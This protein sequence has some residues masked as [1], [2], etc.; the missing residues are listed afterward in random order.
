MTNHPSYRPIALIT[1]AS[2]GIGAAAGRVFTAGGYDTV[3]CARRVEKLEALA[4]ELRSQHPN[5]RIEPIACDVNSDGSVSEAFARISKQF[6]R[7][8]ALVNNAGYGCY[9]PVGEMKLD[10]FRA[11]METNYFGV[12]RCTQAALP[13]LRAAA[14]HECN[15][16]KRW[17]AAI[18]MVSSFVGRRAVPGTSAYCASK[19]ALEGFSEAVRVELHDERISVSVV[20]PGLTRTEF[21]DA[22]H[23]VRPS[24]F[25]SPESGGMT[26]E[27]VARVL[28]RAVKRPR[29]NRYLTFS[30]KSGIAAQW[31]AP[32]FMDLVMTRS[33]RR[34]RK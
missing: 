21:F 18:V 7:L 30:G 6:G 27:D 19:F 22:A 32:S 33:W 8:D 17:G 14:S 20:N 28:L 16:R 15:A 12:I 1:G 24:D 3:L 9:G 10:G 11:V 2:S 5:A 29:R 26:S 13:L 25:L 4:A 34:S 31:L 23:G